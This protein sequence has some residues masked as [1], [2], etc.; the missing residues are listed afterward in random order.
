MVGGNS[1][2][3]TH[4]SPLTIRPG[5]H[6]NNYV[7]LLTYWISVSEMVELTLKF[8]TTALPL[9]KDIVGVVINWQ[10]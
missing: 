1:R 3:T 4:H 6:Q 2:F 10:T 9:N 5:T 8:T 7:P